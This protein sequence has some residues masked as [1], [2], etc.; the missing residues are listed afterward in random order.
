MKKL[1]VGITAPGSVVLLRGQLKFFKDEGYETYLIAPDEIR[2][3]NFCEVEGCTLLPVSIEREISLVADFKSAL[4]IYKHLKRIKPDVV[5]MGTPKM[6]LLGML[7]AWFCGVKTRVY[8]C[9]GFRFEQE[10]GNK[11]K[12]L[13]LM[14]KI[15]GFC[16]HKIIAISPSLKKLAVELNVFPENKVVVINKGSSNGIDLKRFDHNSISKEAVLELK[17]SLGIQ[18]NFC[19]GYVGRLL[20]DKGIN[21]MYHAFESL[22]NENKNLKFLFVGAIEE[23]QIKDKTLLDKIKSHPGIMLL[24]SQSNIPL[25]VSLFD[26]FVMPTYR[27][28]FGNVYIEAAAMGIPVIG[29]DVTGAKDAVHHLYNGIVIPSKSTSELKNA[30]L[31]LIQNNELREKFA[32]NGIQWAKN[33]DNKLIWNEMKVLFQS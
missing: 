4:S 13:V 5:N 19:F 11:R 7:V 17:N 25:Y 10:L 2:T 6:G 33:F 20:D 8:T 24:G 31:N 15:A 32:T 23:G 27:E 14:E 12:V 21:E 30:M 1:V 3:R 26:V 18:Q 22:Y 9:R 29:T 28:G 16:A